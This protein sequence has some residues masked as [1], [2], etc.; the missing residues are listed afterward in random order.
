VK[1]V[2]KEKCQVLAANNGWSL[3]HARGYVDG[4]TFRLR[5]RKPSKY[6]LIGIDEYSSGFRAGYYKRKGP[7]PKAS[8]PK[9]SAA[10]G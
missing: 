6:A 9:V 2:S 7:A 5:G 1:V 10:Q 4:E 3:D 8:P